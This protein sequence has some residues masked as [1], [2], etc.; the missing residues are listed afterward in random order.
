MLVLLTS[1]LSSIRN[2]PVFTAEFK[3]MRNHSALV[4]QQDEAKSE[5]RTTHIFHAAKQA[6]GACEKEP[7]KRRPEPLERAEGWDLGEV[8][9]ISQEFT[10]PTQTL[11]DHQRTLSCQDRH[12]T[13][14]E[15][16]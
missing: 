8:L 16:R 2:A 13:F 14:N 6:A 9:S 15:A 1:T 12:K 10:E 7:N 5:A 4:F 11:H 3:A